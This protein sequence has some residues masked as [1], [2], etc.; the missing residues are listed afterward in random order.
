M[1]RSLVF[2]KMKQLEMNY[3]FLF[4]HQYSEFC[5]CV[6]LLFAYWERMNN[7]EINHLFDIALLSLSCSSTL[8]QGTLTKQQMPLGILL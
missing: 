8:F 6:A 4:P 5:K 1:K 7:W 2:K 3:R